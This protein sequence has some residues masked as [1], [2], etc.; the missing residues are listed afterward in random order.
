LK[1]P[2]KLFPLFGESFG[3]DI[4]I[5]Q[6]RFD[7]GGICIWTVLVAKIDFYSFVNKCFFRSGSLSSLTVESSYALS[8]STIGD[9]AFL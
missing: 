9:S 4:G 8:V 1:P 5:G 3:F 7:S 2:V 6:L